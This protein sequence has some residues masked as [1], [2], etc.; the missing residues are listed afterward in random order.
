MVQ[1]NIGDFDTSRVGHVNELVRGL[2]RV[3]GIA[4]GGRDLEAVSVD[5]DVGAV[6]DIDGVVESDVA[7]KFDSPISDGR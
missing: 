6:V 2:E 1:S 4:I 7:G 5:D 3:G